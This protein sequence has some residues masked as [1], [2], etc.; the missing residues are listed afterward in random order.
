M[1]NPVKQGCRETWEGG[2]AADATPSTLFFIPYSVP[3]GVLC[4]SKPWNL[5][6]PPS[7]YVYNR[8][9]R[10]ARRLGLLRVDW[11]ASGV[12]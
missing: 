11:I 12:C 5:W 8:C 2:G 7:S 9:W 1:V 10:P 6:T 4:P 3:G